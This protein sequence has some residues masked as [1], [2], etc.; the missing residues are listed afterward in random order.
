MMEEMSKCGSPL[1]LSTKIVYKRDEP[2]GCYN[3]ALLS[4][5][6]HIIRFPT[7]TINELTYHGLNMYVK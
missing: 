7:S 4:Y 2:K 5:Q 6:R 3:T 1:L